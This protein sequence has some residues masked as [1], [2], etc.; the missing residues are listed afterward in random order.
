MKVNGL[1]RGGGGAFAADLGRGRWGEGRGR[2]RTCA[3]ALSP[4]FAT[5]SA[6]SSTVPSSNLKRRLITCVS[7][8]MRRLWGP[9]T[10]SGVDARMMISVLM[11]AWRM[12]TP[13]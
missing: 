2:A 1:G 3:C 8:R 12:S 10:K 9:S 6:Y 5:R 4:R 7:S 13:A 11:G